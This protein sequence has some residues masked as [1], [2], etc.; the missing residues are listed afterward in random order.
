LND[1]GIALASG[2]CTADLLSAGLC[3]FAG[4]EES[5]TYPPLIGNFTAA[6][7]TVAYRIVFTPPAS[8]SQSETR[9]LLAEAVA[10]VR[11]GPVLVRAEAKLGR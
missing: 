3:T 11:R 1:I 7:E 6:T 10:R 8:A 2:N 4:V 5:A 9:A